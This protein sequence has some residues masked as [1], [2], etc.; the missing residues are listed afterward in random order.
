MHISLCPHCMHMISFFRSLSPLSRANG[1]Q[2][3]D[4]ICSRPFSGAWNWCYGCESVLISLSVLSS[5][6][7]GL[8]SYPFPTPLVPSIYRQPIVPRTN[9][10]AQWGLI[11]SPLYVFRW[12]YLYL[13]SSMISMCR[14]G[15][16]S[17]FGALCRYI[18]QRMI[19]PA[20]TCT[21]ISLYLCFYTCCRLHLPGKVNNKLITFRRFVAFDTPN[22]SYRPTFLF[23]TSDDP[24]CNAVTLILRG[25][26]VSL[27]RRF[28]F[29]LLSLWMGTSRTCCMR[30][31]REVMIGFRDDS[32][33][34]TRSDSLQGEYGQPSL[35]FLSIPS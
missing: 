30:G 35:Y 8:R 9:M 16:L 1:R 10:C 34:F 31:D 32:S 29:P 15:K 6:V 26:A 7:Y 28:L 27:A 2:R 21:Y 22:A 5:T 25:C 12:T 19:W 14:W 24:A 4:L 33:R 20:H 13:I 11:F 17:S 23:L 18:C 3:A